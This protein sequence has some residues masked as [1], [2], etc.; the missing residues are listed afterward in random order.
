MADASATSPG[1]VLMHLGNIFPEDEW[2]QSS[3]E[4]LV[5]QIEGQRQAK[6]G[7]KHSDSEGIACSA[8][9]KNLRRN[10]RK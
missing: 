2:E 9:Q 1:N 6:R 8:L 4:I 10:A 3:K 7:S 5:V